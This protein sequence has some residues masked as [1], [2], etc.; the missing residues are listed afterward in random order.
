MSYDST[1]DTKAHIERVR[2]LL[3]GCMV[4]L[5]ERRIVHDKS[6]LE[7]PEKEGFDVATPRLAAST[8]GSEEYKGFLAELKPILDHHYA[9][10]SH[11]PEHFP[12]HCP[13]CSKSFSSEQAPPSPDGM[14]AEPR[15]C[16]SCCNPSVI[17]E[18]ELMYRP[19]RGIEGMTLLDVLEMLCDWKAAGER[20]ANGSIARSLEVNRTRF[21]VCGQL[22][23][24]LENT[25]RELGWI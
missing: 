3:T 14:G 2:E 7:S 8:Y 24:I 18:C 19:E 13:V 23:R 1:S 6:K 17:Y 15:F 11:H 12:W 16:P 10:N 5:Q 20:H 4:N 25:E 22:Q 9:A 21:G